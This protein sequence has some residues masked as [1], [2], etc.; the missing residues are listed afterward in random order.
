MKF[1]K[2]GKALIPANGV[3]LLTLILSII[4]GAIEMWSRCWKQRI[5]IVFCRIM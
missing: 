3:G 2:L 5:S 4:R 1:M